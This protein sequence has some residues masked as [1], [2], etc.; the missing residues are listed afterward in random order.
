MP[1]RDIRE[2]G[3]YVATFG[4]ESTGI[5][6]VKIL[7]IDMD[8]A[9]SAAGVLGE[10]GRVLFVRR[11]T[12]VERVKYIFCLC[13]EVHDPADSVPLGRPW[14]SCPACQAGGLAANVRSLRGLWTR[15]S[16]AMEAVHIV[17]QRGETTALLRAGGRKATVPTHPSVPFEARPR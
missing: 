13:L 4:S 11:L 12:E 8:A 3:L 10:P 15:P 2:S 6:S 5:E 7:A 9:L 17:K 14:Q 16:G 1:P